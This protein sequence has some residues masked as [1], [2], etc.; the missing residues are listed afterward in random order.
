MSFS[1]PRFLRRTPSK[2]LKLYFAGRQITLPGPVDWDAPERD[3]LAALQQAVDALDEAARE[4]VITDLER[5]DTLCD[6]VGQL[7]LRSVAADNRALLSRLLTEDSDESRGLIVL[8]EDELAFDHA[9][10]ISYAD[11]RRN[12]RSWSGYSVASPSVAAKDPQLLQVLEDEISRLLRQLDGTGRRLKIDYFDRQ[13]QTTDGRL[14]GLINHYS[15]YAEGLPESQFEFERDEPKRR[16][17]RPVHEGA[18][19]YDPN[20]R[21]LDVIAKGG[22]PARVGIAESF[23]R[24]ILSVTDGIQPIIARRFALNRLKRPLTFASDPADGI[25]TVK[26]LLLR[27]ASAS[28]GHGWITIEIDPSE[29][30]DICALSEQWFGDNDPLRRPEWEVSQAKL[31]IVFHPEP[32]KTRER[33][34]MI[35]L[36]SPNGSNL[37]EQM[38][39][40]QIISEKYLA[41]WGLIAGRPEG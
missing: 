16:T 38:R 32:G 35:E 18:I 12:G 19:S 3:H 20:R 2:S 40:H 23:A 14:I 11:H 33:A 26:V 21:T 10:A 13:G 6:G 4:Q 1:L 8:L 22:K 29:R 7:A 15:I 36:R 5:V 27:L 39:Y 17:R 37:R 31:R 25:K 34:V 9:L 28:D 41:R 30:T 24:N